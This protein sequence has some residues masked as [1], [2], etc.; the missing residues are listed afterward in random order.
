V[1][2]CSLLQLLG[3]MH[4]LHSALLG[5]LISLKLTSIVAEVRSLAEVI[6]EEP[7]LP[8]SARQEL[9]G[10]TGRMLAEAIALQ[11]W[12]AGGS[13]DDRGN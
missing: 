2:F 6:A 11:H 1:P 7:E 12:V 9:L 8:A 3:E 4:A 10:A 5:N 13:D